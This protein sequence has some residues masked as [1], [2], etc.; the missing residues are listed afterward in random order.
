M[1]KG[2]RCRIIRADANPIQKDH[3]N[4]HAGIVAQTVRRRKVL[5]QKPGLF[6]IIIDL[7]TEQADRQLWVTTDGGLSRVI[8][9]AQ[10]RLDLPLVLR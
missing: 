9:G 6:N 2:V 8:G 4:P 7:P 3:E 5:W 1:Q 10:H